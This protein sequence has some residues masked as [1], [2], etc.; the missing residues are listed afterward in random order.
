M[1]YIFIKAAIGLLLLLAAGCTNEKMAFKPE[2]IKKRIVDSFAD[3]ID[4]ANIGLVYLSQNADNHWAIAYN[5][6]QTQAVI[7]MYDAEDRLKPPH[8]LRLQRA[9]CSIDKIELND[10]THDGIFEMIVYARFD[11]GL[12]FQGRQIII[13]ANPFDSAAS[14]IKEIFSHDIEQTWVKIDSFDSEYSTP[15]KRKIVGTEMSVELFE[16]IILL[17]GTFE[18]QR[19]TLREYKW[20]PDKQ[21]FELIANEQLHEATEEEKNKPHLIAQTETGK[22]LLEVVAH[23]FGC[24]SFVVETSSGA[25]VDLPPLV[26]NALSCSPV[27]ALS[28]DGNFLIFTN[29]ARRSLDVYNFATGEI[30]ML[31]E[32]IAALEGLSDIVWSVQNK[33]IFAACII[34][35]PEE[36]LY[37]TRIFVFQLRR[38]APHLV[39]HYDEPAWY[40][41]RSRTGTCTPT[42]EED[43]RFNN[44]G[45]FVYR[46][47][48]GNAPS[49]EFG[50]ITLQIP[51]PPKPTKNKGKK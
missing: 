11:Y 24:R 20:S 36:Y 37:N 6:E 46:L 48:N 18:T 23:D 47:R 5:K 26:Q 17:R 13:Y 1:K 44:K 32:R 8:I 49:Q 19:N 12:S 43:F 35:N 30:K 31:V 42:I 2:E 16:D 45:N 21:I 15:I 40:L 4:T 33:H 3:I 51:A 27:T 25:M 39:T 9:P 14:N 28:P 29:R 50:L 41:C 38:D 34:A 22:L 7:Y 10:A